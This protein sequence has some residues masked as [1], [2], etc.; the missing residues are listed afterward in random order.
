MAAPRASGIELVIPGIGL[1]KR[2]HAEGLRGGKINPPAGTVMWFTGSNR[3]RP[4]QVGTA[5]IAGHVVSRGSGDAFARLAD[6]GVGD[7]IRLTGTGGG[8]DTYR[9]VRAGVVD[10][11]ALTTDQAVWGSNSSVRR[12]AIIT[13]D[14]ARGF[15]SDGHRVANYVVIAEPA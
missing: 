8:V 1:H 7:R 12:L 6:V 13:C 10:K 5:V 4:G 14:D 9:V 3:V 2:L 15:R 11:D